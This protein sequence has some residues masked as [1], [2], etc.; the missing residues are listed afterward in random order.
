MVL[1]YWRM[2]P[3][4]S[5]DVMTPALT[6]REQEV[7]RL[8]IQGCSNAEIAERMGIQVQTVKNR[9]CE[10]YLKTGARNRVGLAM[11]GIRYGLQ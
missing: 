6:R 4:S 5:A 2:G 3:P 10:L 9:L 11:F 8:V 7:I 1:A